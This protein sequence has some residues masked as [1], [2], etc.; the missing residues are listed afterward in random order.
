MIGDNVYKCGEKFDTEKCK[1]CRRYFECK[2]ENGKMK[3][4][5]DIY[6]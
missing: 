4:L 5:V 2:K 3:R 6:H 1:I